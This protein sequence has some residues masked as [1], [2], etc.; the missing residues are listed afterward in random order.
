MPD[1]LQSAKQQF[2]QRMLGRPPFEDHMTAIRGASGRRVEVEISSVPLRDGGQIVGVFGVARPKRRASPAAGQPPPKLTARQHEVLSLLGEGH[3]TTAIAQQ[4]VLSEETVRNHI[5]AVLRQ[6]GA[7]SR[8][9]AVI[10]WHRRGPLE[11]TEQT[12]D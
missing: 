4:L 7:R 8:L 2:A 12:S 3:T 5:K 11:S 10:W 1:R 9:E 6:L